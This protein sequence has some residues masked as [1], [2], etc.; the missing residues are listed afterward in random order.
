MWAVSGFCP[1]IVEGELRYNMVAWAAFLKTLQVTMMHVVVAK[2]RL[3]CTVQISAL[4][5]LS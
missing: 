3:T 5:L 1:R 2:A 4:G